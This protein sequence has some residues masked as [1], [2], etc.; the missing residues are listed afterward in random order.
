[1]PPNYFAGGGGT[2]DDGRGCDVVRCGVSFW[3]VVVGTWCG[4]SPG[5]VRARDIW[6]V[7]S[8]V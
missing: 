2:R 8:C 4:V 3:Q 1:M 7:G 6:R 5:A